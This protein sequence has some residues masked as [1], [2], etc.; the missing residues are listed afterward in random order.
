MVNFQP[1]KFIGSQFYLIFA[2]LIALS[3]TSYGQDNCHYIGQSTTY[4]DGTGIYN[5][6]DT[7]CLQTGQRDYFLFKNIHG[8]AENPI[9]IKNL[10]GQVE[11]I[12][13][14]FYGIKFDNCSYV[15]LSGAGDPS[16]QYGLNISYVDKGTGISIDNLSTDIEIENIELSNIPI[17]GIYAKTEPRCNLESVREN[18]TMFNIKIHD[19]YLHD[20]ADEGFY[21]GSSKYTGQTVEGCGTLMPHIIEGVEIYNN[22]IENTG[23]DGI[24]VSSATKDCKIYN[25]IIRND[26]YRETNYQMSG[27]LIGG[28]SN[29]DCYNNKIFDGKGDGIDILGLGNHKIFNNLIVRPGQ[30]YHSNESPTQFQKH[31]IW[32]GN[33]VSQVNSDFLIYNNTIV[34]PRTYGIRL[35]DNLTSN[36]KIYNNIIVDP[37]AYDVLGENSFTN[38][39]M[40][41]TFQ[42]SNNLFEHEISD[43]QFENI[44]ADNYDLKA[45]SPA[46]DAGINLSSFGLTFDIDDRQR[47]YGNGYDIG[48]YESQDAINAIE[49]LINDKN[50]KAILKRVMPNPIIMSAKIKYELPQSTQ[51]KL[52]VI[53]GLGRVVRILVNEYQ[54]QNSYQLEID[55]GMFGSGFFYLILE[56][57]LG[58][59]SKKLVII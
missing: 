34:S 32:V 7:L 44:Q 26:S 11:I 41:I 56:C 17:A 18:F 22:I 47:P 16:V 24:Q 51:V 5:P 1:L 4:V 36:F 25:N 10:T 58:R 31:G 3:T 27:I 42:T 43:A 49:E 48:A 12:T 54:A 19:C 37:G 40:G 33:V 29:C 21:I 14:H 45:S 6:G 52:Y 15:K 57:D 23:W 20:I 2:L 46:I 38:I 28:G 9:V 53:D 59:Y 30:T 55:K 35:Y 50:E 8:T 13:P 39:S